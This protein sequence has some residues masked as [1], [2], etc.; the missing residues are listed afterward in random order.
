MKFGPLLSISSSFGGFRELLLGLVPSSRLG[1]ALGNIF[2]TK[3][4]CHLE[5][6]MTNWQ[7]MGRVAFLFAPSFL[8]F[9]S[10]FLLRFLLLL[11]IG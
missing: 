9:L 8:S 4:W 7:G 11:I 5:K 6:E 1:A 2:Q 10:S 3:N